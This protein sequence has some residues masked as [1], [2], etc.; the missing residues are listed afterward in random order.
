MPSRPNSPKIQGREGKEMGGSADKVHRIAGN[1]DSTTG[2]L[3][4]GARLS[5]I[6]RTTFYTP[7][8]GLRRHSADSMASKLPI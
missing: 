1:V 6:I 5:G 3:M 8:V 4:K 7:G 2:K